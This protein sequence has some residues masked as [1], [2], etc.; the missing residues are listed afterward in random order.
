VKR[1]TVN[2]EIRD[3]SGSLLH[4]ETRGAFNAGVRASE[5]AI[6]NIARSQRVD[7]FGDKPLRI[8]DVYTRRW[9]STRG[10]VVA[11]IEKKLSGGSP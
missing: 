6:R 8:A 5:S 1:P 2:V 10:S 7:Y 9:T 11:R 3:E 4:S